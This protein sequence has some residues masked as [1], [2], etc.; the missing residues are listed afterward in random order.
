M[1][2][3]DYH[4]TRRRLGAG[5]TAALAH[6]LT[7]RL[8]VVTQQARRGR[9][10]AP[11]SA[12]KVENQDQ[13][14]ITVMDTP[15]ALIHPHLFGANNAWCFVPSQDFNSFC[16]SLRR[17]AG[18]TLLRY[19]GGFES[20]NYNWAD[21][22]VNPNYRFHPS[23]P[24]ATPKQTIS[25][26][27]E[28]NV[29]FVLR[30]LDAFR[31][32]TPA[33][34][35]HWAGIAAGLVVRYGSAVHDW[36]LGNEWYHFGGAVKHYA[37]FVRRY[38]QLV[39]HF[40][41]VIRAAAREADHRINLYISFN[42]A[43][44]ADIQVMRS[45]IPPAV[46]A[47]IDGFN[48]HAYSGF[49]PTKRK[50]YSAPAIDKIAVTIDQ[51]KRLS[52]LRRVYVSEWMAALNDNHRY[53]GIKNAAFM[54]Q[55]IGQFAEAGVRCAAYWPSV[56]PGRHIPQPGRVTLLACDS[57][58]SPDAAGQLMKLLSESYRGHILPLRVRGEKLWAIAARS[59]EGRIALFVAG[60]PEHRVNISVLIAGRKVRR[61]LRSRV[62]WAPA[63]HLDIGPAQIAA[64]PAHITSS[65]AGSRC[66][67]QLN[68]G[69]R[70]RGSAW[71]IACVEI[72]CG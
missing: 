30:T 58:W 64:L 19:P 55:M 1:F 52:G 66:E 5:F 40:V 4:L 67:L 45:I 14:H 33:A 25:A 56:L 20:E 7:H 49:A 6:G 50:Y 51:L 9:M 21:N 59:P 61:V 3:D 60:G 2:P 63:S 44:P 46:W 34:Y 32:G 48:I 68:P 65:L 47:G 53:G 18:V 38:A 72:E 13:K 42:W 12:G 11:A 22:T 41:P 54:L 16:S 57:G 71:E 62:M 29:S 17:N 31:V 10:S 24:G 27:G 8:D 37:A 43:H 70:G 23:E 35:K 69:G 26:M 36:E 39:A 15:G 28:G